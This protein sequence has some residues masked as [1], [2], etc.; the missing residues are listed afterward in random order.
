MR[1]AMWLVVGIISGCWV[2]SNRYLPYYQ[3]CLD[4]V[5]YW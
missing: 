5:K 2:W 4:N 3:Y 1:I